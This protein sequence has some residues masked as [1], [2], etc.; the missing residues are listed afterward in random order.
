M[1]D[2]RDFVV[3]EVFLL[4]IISRVVLTDLSE[5]LLRHGAEVTVTDTASSSQHHP[6]SL[7]VGV[8]VV[9]QVVTGD[10]LDVLGGSE[11]G[12]AKGSSL[13]GNSMEMIKHNLLKIHLHLLHLPDKEIILNIDIQMAR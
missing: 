11:D 6:W 10:A 7:V 8:D 3:G 9:D 2:R 4:T 12:S 13:V 1:L 5:M